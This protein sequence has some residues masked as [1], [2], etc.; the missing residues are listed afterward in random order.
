MQVQITYLRSLGRPW[1]SRYRVREIDE[2]FP[3]E[4]STQHTNLIRLKYSV[5]L[6]SCFSPLSIQ[7]LSFMQFDKPTKTPVVSLHARAQTETRRSTMPSECISLISTVRRLIVSL[8]FCF[9]SRAAARLESYE[10]FSVSSPGPGR[11]G[12]IQFMPCARSSRPNLRY[13]RFS[14]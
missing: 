9:L 11:S 6:S 13:I 7:I 10:P 12:F 4:N 5:E 3:P 1:S 8:L 14:L 2:A